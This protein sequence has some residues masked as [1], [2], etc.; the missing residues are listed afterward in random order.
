MTFEK[1]ITN[2]ECK[3]ELSFLIS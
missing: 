2:A 3:C 1:P